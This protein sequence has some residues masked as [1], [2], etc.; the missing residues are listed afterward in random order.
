MKYLVRMLTCGMIGASTPAEPRKLGGIILGAKTSGGSTPRFF[1]S[2][3]C[4]AN[5]NCSIVNFPDWLVS[6]SALWIDF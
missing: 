3:K 5:E 2:T 4:I 1:S 6:H